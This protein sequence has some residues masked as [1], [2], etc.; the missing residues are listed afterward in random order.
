MHWQKAASSRGTPTEERF[1]PA[2]CAGWGGGLTQLRL[3][4]NDGRRLR[5]GGVEGG[6]EVGGAVAVEADVGE[7]LGEDD[8]NGDEDGAGA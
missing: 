8:T 7:G 4:S 1:H 3:G 5:L 6:L 2:K